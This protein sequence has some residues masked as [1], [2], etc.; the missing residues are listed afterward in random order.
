M[1][2]SGGRGS[3]AVERFAASM[4]LDYERWHDGV[5]YDLAALRDARPEERAAIETMLLAHASRG[6]RD[7]E[8]LAALDT[9]RARAALRAWMGDEDAEVRLA[10]T[11]FAPGLVAE[12]QRVASL[13]RA[14]ETAELY[15]GL[16][17]AL[18]EAAELHPPEVVAALLRG[19]RER[20]GTAAVHYAALLLFI[21]GQ[22]EEPFDM[23]Q[24]PFLLRFA[25]DD[26]REREAAFAE[27]CRRLG[28]DAPGATGSAGPPPA[29]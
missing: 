20:D 8:A 1:N 14:L 26:R 24:R 7:V 11:R 28:R 13:V 12:P 29:A 16:T 2:G 10:I 3:S 15:G 17:Q 22:A 9:P 6:W 21:H 19:A 4:R 25:G 23:A 18:D 27:L 5:G